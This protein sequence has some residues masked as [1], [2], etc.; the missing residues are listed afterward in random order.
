MALNHQY[1]LVIPNIFGFKG[2]IQIYSAFL[3]QGL[4]SIDSQAHYQVL[5][6]YDRSYPPNHSFLPQTNFHCFGGFYPWIQSSLMAVKMV[7]LALKNSSQ[8]SSH[9]FIC[10]HINYS[11]VCYY[12]KYLFGIRYWVVAHGL[13]VWN[14]K[15]PKL[16]K[17]LH[18]ADKILT[19]S[20]YTRDRLLQE[21]N[22]NSEQVVVLPNTFE[23]HR[24]QIA[25]KPQYLL[26]RYH[27]NPDQP[28]IL[29]VTRLGKS[30]RYKGYDQILQALVLIRQSF[31]NIHYILVGKGDDTP[32]IN[33]LI[34]K[35]GLEDSV[36]LTGLIPDE[37]LC[38]HYNLCD[39]FA[40]PSQGEGFGIVYLE[41]L[42][43]GKPVLAGNQDGAVDPLFHGELGCL[44]DPQDVRVIASSLLQILQETYSNQL[45]YN[46]QYLRQK[47][48]DNFGIQRFQARLSF[49]VSP[50]YD[51]PK[52][53]RNCVK[54]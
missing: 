40:L 39:V 36:T 51:L 50:L 33:T 10:T 11:L 42:A 3:L 47:T 28:I 49:E 23:P 8:N 37:E 7:Q 38:D 44:V 52:T 15:S 19:V 43:C 46:H 9:L 29:S 24:F 41:A 54:S 31:P 16:K 5:L 21:Q 25:S 27:L 12:L 22:L 26:K 45:L 14:L 2:G 30:A 18:N 4:Q 6:K 13:E 34:Q 1:T 35:L 17:A 32:R 53:S 20:H 48:I